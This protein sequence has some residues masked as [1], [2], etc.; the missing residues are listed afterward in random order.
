MLVHP[1]PAPVVTARHDLQTG[2]V[3]SDLKDLK[4]QCHGNREDQAEIAKICIACFHKI[5]MTD[6]A[7]TSEKKMY[8]IPAGKRQVIF[9]YTDVAVVWWIMGQ[10]KRIPLTRLMCLPKWQEQSCQT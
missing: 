8:N 7:I 3:L 10:N 4:Q 1:E 2:W 9:L 6:S 5:F